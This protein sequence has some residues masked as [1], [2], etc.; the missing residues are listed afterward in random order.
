MT[1][2]NV[3]LIGLGT[4]GAP[5]GR[6]VL[7]AGYPLA[8]YDVNPE[9]V[10]ALVADG[11]VGCDSPREVAVRSDAVMTI[12][13]DSPDVEAVI[14]GPDGV[15]AGAEPGTLI[16]E[17]ST[18]NPAT[19]RKVAAEAGTHGVRMI[20][21]PVCRSSR[22]AMEGRLMVLVGGSEAD[23]EAS[24]PLLGAVGDTFHHCGE[25]GTG[26]TM[27]LINN[28]MGQGIAMAVCEC[29]TLGVKAGLSLE[30]MVE[31]LSGTAVSNRMMEVAYANAA[32]RGDFSLGFP[33]DWAH[34]DVGHMLSLA[35]ELSAPAPAAAM[36]HQLQAVARSQGKGRMDHSALLMVF[37]ALAGVKV[38]SDK[39]EPGEF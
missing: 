29:L 23:F 12:V 36:V 17:M 1:I 39:I 24:L 13:P 22:H 16:L 20:D 31:V 25:I 37:E 15:L 27:K 10:D 2:T 30:Q 3:G 4:M 35:A 18:I 5:M 9:A 8:V 6:N 38:R 21:A 33:L 26:I 34:K 11:A 28:A 32:F 14:L 19:T 7:K